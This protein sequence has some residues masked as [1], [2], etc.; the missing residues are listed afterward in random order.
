[1]AYGLTAKRKIAITGL[2]QSGKTSFLTSLL[3]QLHE[4]ENALFHL[5]NNVRI[6]QFREVR[7][8]ST[9]PFDRF[10]S[11]MSSENGNWPTKTTDT[12]RY[13]C[14]F[15]RS[16]RSRARQVEFVDFP[17]ERIADAGIALYDDYAT[18]SRYMFSQFAADSSHRGAAHAFEQELGNILAASTNRSQN[19]VENFDPRLQQIAHS[20]KLLL[21]R[22]ARDCRILVSP[23][24]FMLD[25]HGG[26]ADGENPEA[27]AEQRLCGLDASS[28]FAPLPTSMLNENS[29]LAQAM[30]THYKRYRKEFVMP[31]FGNVTD[32]QGVIVTVDITSL[33]AGGVD[34]YNDN[35]AVLLALFESM[36]RHSSIHRV[37]NI[38]R[39][40]R[41]W[42]SAV[43]RVA[44]VATKSDLVREDDLKKDRLKSLLRSMTR[45]VKD[46]L[47]SVEIRWFDC[48]AC[49]STIQMGESRLRAVV[50]YDRE[51]P[52]VEFPVSALPDE[53]PDEWGPDCYRFRRVAARSPRNIQKPPRHRN[54]DA[55]FD[56]V[57][58]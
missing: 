28:Q 4:F 25:R 14:T 52:W 6:T 8:A 48:S 10:R 31:T 2:A 43:Q 16:D 38:F 46:L 29:G 1:M 21:A 20:Y 42:S 54:L 24:I 22:Y 36:Q 17:G 9:F 34:R 41:L 32:A 5:E 47:P 50:D 33:L 19:G 53:W 49:I 55:V 45:R 57:A 27:L 26:E 58:M 39:K 35:C 51:R 18:W 30:Q 15:K 44:F 40:L 12:H 11:L 3:W 56:F 13:I 23:S 7:A 37:L